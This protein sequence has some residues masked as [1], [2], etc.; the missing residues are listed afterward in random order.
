MKKLSRQDVTPV[1]E[2]RC[3]RAEMAQAKLTL[4]W[5]G[6]GTFLFTTPQ[7]RRILIDPWL[8]GNPACPD[9]LKTVGKLDLI[10]VTHGHSD[11]TGDAVAIATKTGAP[12]VANFE[13]CQWLSRQG[14]ANVLPMNKG[15]TQ[16]VAGARITM[17][18]ALHS[19]SYVD[20]S[21]ITYLGE[22]AGYVMACDGAPTVYFAGDTAVFGDMQLIGELYAPEVGVLPI[23][24]LYTMGPREAAKACALLGI[25]KVVPM[26][27]GTFPAL[28]GTLQ[29]LR[30]LVEPRGIEV[31]A[32]DPGES[33][34][35]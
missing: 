1:W 15:G 19:S 22:A 26:H 11:H 35:L 30:T 28:T 16:H 33:A 4:T 13:V 18:Q 27:F 5:C 2:P 23:G 6:H 3:G 17:V 29:T 32:L 24:D 12:V 25:R 34:E 7:Q 21:G 8:M 14:I 31:V 9:R 20:A 10:L